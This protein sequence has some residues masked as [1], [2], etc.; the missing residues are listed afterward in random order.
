MSNYQTET[1]WFQKIAQSFE[2]YIQKLEN[3]CLFQVIKFGKKTFF[4]ILYIL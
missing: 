3:A 2:S 1:E 4:Y